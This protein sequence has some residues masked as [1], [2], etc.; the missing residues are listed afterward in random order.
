M[1]TKIGDLARH[2]GVYG[3]GTMVGGIARAALVPI[4]ARYVPA[5][6]YGKASV[7]LIFITLLGIISELGLSS[8]LIKF[9]NE[10]PDEERRCRIVSTILVASSMLAVAIALGC[11]LLAGPLSEFLLGSGQYK[12]LILIGIAGGLGN[13]LLQVGLSFERA[14]ARSR[15]Y[16][17]YTLAKGVL[18]LILSI[19][20]V[21]ALRKGAVGL[22]IGSAIPP[23]AIGLV[24]YGRLLRRY[25]TAFSRRIFRSVIE[26]GSPLVP[27]NLAMWVLAYSDIYLLR[28]LTGGGMALSEVGLY[29]Y[30]HEICLL[31][32]LPIM[33]LNLAWPQFIF[34]NHSKPG[35]NDMFSRA[36]LYFSFFLVEIGF[37]LSLFARGIVGLVGSAE[38]AESASVIPLLA[39]SLVFY[40]FSIVFS[41]GLYVAGK[42]RVLAVTVTACAALNVVLNIQLI[43]G[44]GKQGA[45]LATLATNL[46][47]AVAILAFSQRHYRIPFR[48]ARTLGGTILA[49]ALIGLVAWLDRGGLRCM[50]LVRLVAACGFSLGLLGVLGMKWRDIGQGLRTAASLVKPG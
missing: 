12:T 30:A 43:P 1:S 5:E 21:V 25:A 46:V 16:V 3:V 41:S 50:W 26:F 40:G 8:S 47:M 28:R 33:S 6:E 42:T 23:V 27:M 32:V 20:L 44:M 7:V 2:T 31:L 13:A 38:Y 35:A 34:S 14:H 11:V 29:Q 49:G 48:L 18:A 10:A 39:G 9:V 45:A 19:T 4:I 24:I 17:V 22:L 37:L 15:R 36:H